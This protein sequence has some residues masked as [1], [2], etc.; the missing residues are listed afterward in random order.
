MS[1]RKRK[2]AGRDRRGH[3]DLGLTLCPR[4]RRTLIRARG[5]M[6]WLSVLPRRTLGLVTKHQRPATG[7]SGTFVPGKP[8]T[9]DPSKRTRTSETSL[10]EVIPMSSR[11]SHD[12]PS[13]P[14][15]FRRLA[16]RA[17]QDESFLRLLSDDPHAAL[18]EARIEPAGSPV[19]ATD[20][21]SFF[22]S[23]TALRDAIREEEFPDL[24][25]TDV[26][27]RVFG[28]GGTPLV[29]DETTGTHTGYNEG[30]SD[31]SHS[32]ACTDSGTHR[33]F[34]HEFNPGPLMN[35]AEVISVSA[36]IGISPI[37]LGKAVKP[38]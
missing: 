4:Q 5:C 34:P 32:T 17:L 38:E 27:N 13:E 16:E 10:V 12:L 31:S 14:D 21:S 28:T 36:R 15:K 22:A 2:R 1:G 30:W 8:A 3:S 20:L 33:I 18:R 24:S 26:F 9:F 25:A 23:L 35:P 29:A 11:I 7:G 6:G 37:S 19:Q